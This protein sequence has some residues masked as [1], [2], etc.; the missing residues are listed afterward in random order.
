V[1]AGLAPGEVV[2]YGEVA[3]EAGFPGAA[4][5]VGAIL[6][7]GAAA[8][9]RLG[10]GE[11]PWWRVVTASGRLVPGHEAEHGRRLVAEG[12]ATTNGKVARRPPGARRVAVRRVAGPPEP[13][14]GRHA[15]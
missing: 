3:T 2:S 4:R 12:V 14:G 10:G 13:R 8:P 7:S 9:A 15:P 5:A 6:A 1:I 11:L